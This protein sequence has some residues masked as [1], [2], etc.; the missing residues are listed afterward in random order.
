MNKELAEEEE[1]V[2]PRYSLLH[3]NRSLG[4]E[5]LPFNGSLQLGKR[6]RKAVEI[7]KLNNRL[8]LKLQL[9]LLLLLLLPESGT[10]PKKK[11][12]QLKVKIN[13]DW[14]KIS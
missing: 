12:L 5:P 7:S 8:E 3:F 6:D 11:A 2:E 13:F 14:E 9:L 10:P 4:V 1:E